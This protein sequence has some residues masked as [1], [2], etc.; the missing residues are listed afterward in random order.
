MIKPLSSE[1]ARD[2]LRHC[3]VAR[4][5]CIAG[6]YPYVVPVNY[7]VHENR[8]Y[9]HSLPGKKIEALR[10]NPK[11]CVQVDKVESAF[12][13][14]SAIAFGEYREVTDPAER[15]RAITELLDKFPNLTPVE[16]VPVHDGGSSIIVFCIEI[17]RVSGVADS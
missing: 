7:I 14:R 11:A 13:W 2:L 17:D 12:R 3:N 5:A 16:S 6:D 4:L 15:N 1:D 9:T 8:I 10:E